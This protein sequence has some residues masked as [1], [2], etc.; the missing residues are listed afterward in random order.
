MKVTLDYVAGVIDGEGTITLS[1]LH[2][3]DKWRTPVVSVSSTTIEILNALVAV[4]GGHVCT[5]KTYRQHHL[6]S[7]SWRISGRKAVDVCAQLNA[8]LLVPS[9]R[10]RAELIATKY[11][12]CTPRNGKYTDTLTRKKQQFENA[13]FHPSEPLPARL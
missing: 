4:F 2:K 1:R 6:P 5:H 12:A 7:F 11:V 8:L 13:F 10:R 3:T 9:K